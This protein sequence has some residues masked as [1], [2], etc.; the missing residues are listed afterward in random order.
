MARPK[1]KR[2]VQKEQLALAVRKNFNAL[3]V[4]ETDVIVDLLYKVKNQ[5]TIKPRLLHNTVRLYTYRQRVP[6]T[7]RAATKMINRARAYTSRLHFR[8]S[9]HLHIDTQALD[10]IEQPRY[11]ITSMDMSIEKAF[12]YTHDFELDC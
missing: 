4:N 11:S 12:W 3:G 5:G 8:S 9:S 1:T 7:I 2:R 10:Y 6:S